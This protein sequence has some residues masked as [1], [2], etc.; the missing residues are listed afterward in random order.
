MKRR[1]DPS[2][3]R[4]RGSTSPP[5][6]ARGSAL[7]RR[8]PNEAPV[9]AAAA[10]D[11]AQGRL[12][13]THEDAEQPVDLAAAE[14]GAPALGRKAG[15]GAGHDAPADLARGIGGAVDYLSAAVA[16]RAVPFE[17]G[18]P[19]QRGVGLGEI[20]GAERD[21]LRVEPLGFGERMADAHALELL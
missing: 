10:E 5:T 17:R 20:G 9:F 18:R 1:L 3:A 7:S 13:A 16:D 2:P 12:A 19:M 4:C 21:R 6:R 15:D 11:A 8:C 14:I